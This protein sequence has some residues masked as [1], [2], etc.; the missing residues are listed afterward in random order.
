M[1]ARPSSD[2]L[3]AT[4]ELPQ[5]DLKIISAALERIDGHADETLSIASPVSSPDWKLFD[6]LAE[7]QD[8]VASL[9]ADLTENE[10]RYSRLSARHE[11]LLQNLHEHET[12]LA[13]KQHELNQSLEKLTHLELQQAYS[14]NETT[15]LREARD[16]LLRDT[17]R[18]DRD[19]AA[20]Q[21]ALTAAQQ[22]IEQ[23]SSDAESLKRLLKKS[24]QQRS[25]RDQFIIKQAREIKRLRELIP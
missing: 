18:R 16:K 14:L 22:Q 12:R 8:Q 24:I 5:L 9:Q 13:G 20:H 25:E 7:L 11:T 4:K 23:L 10:N 21:L 15:T 17:A 3:D 2:D 1:N 6:Q 19:F